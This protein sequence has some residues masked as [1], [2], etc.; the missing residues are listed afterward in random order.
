MGNVE[1]IWKYSP[2]FLSSPHDLIARAALVIFASQKAHKP[3]CR[4]F[5]SPAMP[6]NLG[7]SEVRRREDRQS[8][9]L[10]RFL[11]P[12]SSG[13]PEWAFSAMARKRHLPV[14]PQT[15]LCA[16]PWVLRDSLPSSRLP[17]LLSIPPGQHC[18]TGVSAACG[19]STP[20]PYTF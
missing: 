8:R 16:L 19:T 5:G 20:I 9:W 7:R 17:L 2:S 11:S 18:L 15:I 3:F 4:F 13:T 14:V 10:T 12:G 1:N 6:E